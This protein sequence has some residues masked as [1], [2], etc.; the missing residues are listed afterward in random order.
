MADEELETAGH[1]ARLR[2]RLIDGG[3]DALLDH[4]IVEFLLTLTIPRV[5][6]KAMA[7]DLIRRFGS[8]PHRN[9]IL[10]RPMTEEEQ[11]YLDNGGFKG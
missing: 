10:G 6:T 7:K 3:P 9:P 2:Q 4:E 11:R 1:R 8:F 5:D